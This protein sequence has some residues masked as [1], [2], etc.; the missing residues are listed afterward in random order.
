MI[1][2]VCFPPR[3]LYQSIRAEMADEKQ[4]HRR[5]QVGLVSLH[6]SGSVGIGG[7]HSKQ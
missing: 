7:L 2:S 6:S 3:N 1:R 4:P 5:G